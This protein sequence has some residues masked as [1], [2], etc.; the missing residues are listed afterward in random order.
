MSLNNRR[1]GQS[2]HQILRERQRRREANR[3]IAPGL[4]VG[5]RLHNWNVLLVDVDK[6]QP[7]SG[8]PV[9]G[10]ERE[11]QILVFGLDRSRR[12]NGQR[13]ENLQ[14][15]RVDVRAGLIDH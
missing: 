1:N 5:Y 2:I 12:D 6:G 7:C 15:N 13:P 14:I 10:L 9:L 3:P 11:L 4:A 8:G